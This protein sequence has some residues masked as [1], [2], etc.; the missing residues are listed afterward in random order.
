MIL[1]VFTNVN[2]I[3]K[4]VLLYSI[5][6]YVYIIVHSLVINVYEDNYSYIPALCDIYDYKSE[7]LFQ[8]YIIIT[9]YYTLKVTKTL[10][11]LLCM[12]LT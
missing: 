7:N 1:N 2:Y 11:S 12:L 4:S 6:T 8:I 5:C 10:L 9:S 3:V